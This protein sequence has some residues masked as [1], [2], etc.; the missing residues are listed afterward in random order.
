MSIVDVLIVGGG[1]SGL[2]AALT[3]VRQRHTVRVFDIDDCRASP[4]P[5]LHAVT[6]CEHELEA[7]DCFTLNKVEVTNLKAIGEGFEATDSDGATYTGRKVILANGVV[8]RFPQIDGYADCFGKG[9]FHNLFAQAYQKDTSK[10]RCGVLAVDWI[11]MPQFT[12][13]LSHLGNQL[14]AS[15]TVYTNG[16]EELAATVKP[17]FEGKPWK[18]DTRKIAKLA[19]RAQDAHDTAVKITFEDGETVTED[20]VGHAPMTIVRGPFAEQLG[21]K[22]S[23]I[24]GGEYETRPPFFATEV[25]GV[26]AAGDVVTPFKVW[27]NASASGAQAAAGVAVALQEQKW[28]LPPLFP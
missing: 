27:P 13:H 15:V 14:A 24:G 5:H 2:S 17:T 6:G 26:Y 7:Y 23:A 8:S 10:V 12:Y 16:S 3:L 18:L 28:N 25:K 11:A 1:P 21:L 22:L 19:L 4:S 9:I 20:F